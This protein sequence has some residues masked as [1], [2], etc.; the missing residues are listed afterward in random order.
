MQRLMEILAIGAVEV[1]VL[2]DHHGRRRVPEDVVAR[3]DC[4]HERCVSRVGWRSLRHRRIYRHRDDDA[5]ESDCDRDG[6]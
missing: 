4:S 6:Q 1:G 2:D 5:A 3:A